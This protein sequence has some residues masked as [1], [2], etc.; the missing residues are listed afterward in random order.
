M[1]MLIDLSTRAKFRVTGG[2]RVRFLNGQLTNDLRDGKPGQTTYACVLT[3][4]GKLCGDLF[5]TPFEDTFLL[6]CHQALRES[7]L[8][9]LEKYAIADDVEFSDQ[10][11]EFGL[12]HALAP[13]IPKSILPEATVSRSNRFGLE[14]YDLLV[15][16]TL[17]SVVPEVL[18]EQVLDAAEVETFRIERGI[19]EWGHELNENVIPNEAGLDQT[20]VSYTKGCYVGQEVISRLKS[21]GHVNRQLC[22]IQLIDGSVLTEGDKLLNDSGQQTGFVTSATRSQQLGAWIGLA[23]V[24][25]NF[26]QPGSRYRLQNPN[27]S[28]LIGTAEL[29]SLPI[30][31]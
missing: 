20:A 6:D 30:I 31:P 28:D 11:N 15:P 27:N 3:A 25:R 8:T 29:R 21:L 14:G 18:K 12:F 23:Y 5:V 13:E 1:N 17:K 7:L 4:K 10:T 26:V 19:P 2:D 22:S 16:A 9:R 24:K